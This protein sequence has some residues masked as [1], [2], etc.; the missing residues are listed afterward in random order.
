[1]VSIHKMHVFQRCAFAA[2]LLLPCTVL[3]DMLVVIGASS[4]LNA[5]D[6]NQ[7]RDIFLGRI[8]SFPDSSIP[9]LIDLPESSSLREAF[10]MRVANMSAAQAKAHWAKLYFTG[11]GVPPQEVT[12]SDEV[13]KVVN[14]TPDA[15]GYIDGKSLDNSVKVLLVLP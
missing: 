5:L 8:V 13:K 14:A 10:Y 2:L 15:I 1:M 11:R 12:S 4:H 6:K 3:A 7:V 9:V